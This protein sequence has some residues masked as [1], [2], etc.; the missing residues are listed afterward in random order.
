MSMPMMTP[1]RVPTTGTV[2]IHPET[3]QA[4]LRQ[5]NAL[6]SPLQRATPSVDPVMHMVV[7][8]LDG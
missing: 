7:E 1:E 6:R 8:T 3:I 4:R 5:L 2:M